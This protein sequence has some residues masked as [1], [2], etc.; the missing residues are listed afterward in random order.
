[1]KRDEK[2]RKMKSEKEGPGSTKPKDER[3]HENAQQP[4]HEGSQS[5]GSGLSEDVRK[6]ELE[7]TRREEEEA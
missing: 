3:L 2:R 4:P 6:R 5:H 7:E 1:M